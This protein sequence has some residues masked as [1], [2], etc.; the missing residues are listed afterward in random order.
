M[1]GDGLA[2]IGGGVALFPRQRPLGL[3][4][5]YPAGDVNVA[6]AEP[7]AAGQAAVFFHHHR[8]V[9]GGPVGGQDT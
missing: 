9:L 5:L 8:G 4:V 1:L 6:L 3:L 7:L 2:V